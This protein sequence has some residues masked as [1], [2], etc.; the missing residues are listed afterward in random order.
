[1][2]EQHPQENVPSSTNDDGRGFAVSSLVLGVL[3]LICSCV[4]IGGL[5]MSIIALVLGSMAKKRGQDGMATAGIVLGIIGIVFAIAAMIFGGYEAI[6]EQQQS[7][8][9]MTQ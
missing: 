7:N 9:T 4:P 6:V 3:G 2:T 8:T 5:P 1:M